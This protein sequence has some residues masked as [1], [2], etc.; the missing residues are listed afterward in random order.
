M[1]TQTFTMFDVFEEVDELVYTFDSDD[2]LEAWSLDGEDSFVSVRP[3][4]AEDR[5]D[6]VELQAML[7]QI[8]AL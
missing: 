4:T 7:D 3:A 5:I 8:S 2:A 6:A 1:S